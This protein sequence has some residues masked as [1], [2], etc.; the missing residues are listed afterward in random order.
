MERHAGLVC[1]EVCWQR[2]GKLAG[3]GRQVAEAH[4]LI[5]AAYE[6]ALRSYGLQHPRLLCWGQEPVHMVQTMWLAC[7]GVVVIIRSITKDLSQHSS[8]M[9]SC[10]AVCYHAQCS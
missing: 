8:Y 2:A 10:A 9:V 3:P 1:E 5:Q 7:F 6:P 4:G